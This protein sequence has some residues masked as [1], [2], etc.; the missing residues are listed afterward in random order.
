MQIKGHP[1]A[2]PSSN[3]E[4]SSRKKKKKKELRK[5]LRDVELFPLQARWASTYVEHGGV[6]LCEGLLEVRCPVWWCCKLKSQ[7][8]CSCSPIFCFFWPAELLGLFFFSNY[9][10]LFRCSG[11]AFLLSNLNISWSTAGRTDLLTGGVVNYVS[12]V[13]PSLLLFFNYPPSAWASLALCG[14]W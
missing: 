9:F 8:F 6:C 13:S 12:N 14:S 1:S 4:C 3:P 11:A 7:L 10:S 2:L 5:R